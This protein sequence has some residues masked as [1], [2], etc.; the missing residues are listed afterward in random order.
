VSLQFDHIRFFSVHSFVSVSDSL[1]HFYPY[2]HSLFKISTKMRNQVLGMGFF[3]LSV[4]NANVYPDCV[5]S[6]AH[7]LQAV[8]LTPNRNLTTATETFLIPASSLKPRVSA[9]SFCRGQLLLPRRFRTAS[10]IAVAMSMLLALP[11]LVLLIL[12]S[13]LLRRSPSQRRLTRRIYQ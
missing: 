4:V 3:A 13:K 6:H 8:K 1:T 2:R 10:K 5:R 7:K 11:A 12:M 9:R